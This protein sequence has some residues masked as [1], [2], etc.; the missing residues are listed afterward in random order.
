MMVMSET[1]DHNLAKA[2]SL[3]AKAAL[4]GAGL[5]LLPELFE[6]PYFCQVEDYQ[7]FS[8]AEE[9][10]QSKTLEH[11]K[12]IARKYHGVPYLDGGV[13]CPIAFEKA[14]EEGYEKI[15]VIATREKGYRKSEIKP[16]QWRL[17][18]RMYRDYPFFLECYSRSS[19]IYNAEMEKMAAL[20]KAGR[21]FVLYP[22]EAPKVKHSEMDKKA[23]QNLI[24][25]GKKDAVE[26]LPLLKTYLSK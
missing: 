9:A 16:L 17:V 26:A 21:L 11:F 13:A 1:Y 15:I 7:K 14:L 2:D 18:S 5:V 8:L 10:D 23:L 4:N 24:D 20:E 3:I 19:A 6:G 22:S 12:K 25:L